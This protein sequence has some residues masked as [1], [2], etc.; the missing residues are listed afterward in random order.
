MTAGDR[1]V[2]R[3]RPA[4]WLMAAVVLFLLGTSGSATSVISDVPSKIA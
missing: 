4:A 3:V 2:T 1:A